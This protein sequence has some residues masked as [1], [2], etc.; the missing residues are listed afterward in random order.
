MTTGGSLGTGEA[1]DIGT[2]GRRWRHL[3]LDDKQWLIDE[4]QIYISGR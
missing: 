2:H 1:G 4:L 3:I